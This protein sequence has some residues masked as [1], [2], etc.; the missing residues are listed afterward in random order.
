MAY[1][2]IFILGV[3]VG[4][5]LGQFFTVQ[6]ASAQT[7]D[8]YYLTITGKF[9][10]LQAQSTTTLPLTTCSGV[11]GWSNNAEYV[12]LEFGLPAIHAS[13]TYSFN[14]GFNAYTTFQ[15]VTNA[16]GS[17]DWFFYCANPTFLTWYNSSGVALSDYYIQATSSAANLGNFFIEIVEPKYA[18]TTA[19]STVKLNAYFYYDTETAT[20]TKAQ[21][22]IFDYLSNTLE[23]EYTQIVPAGFDVNFSLDVDT[24]LATGSKKMVARY[25][26]AGSELSL[27]PQ[28]E[29]FFSVIENTYF[30]ATGLES[31]TAT[32]QDLTQIDCNTFDV[33]CQFQKALTFLF[34]PPQT[35]L[36]KFGN[37]WQ[38]LKYL[39]P[40]GYVTQ[41]FEQLGSVSAGAAGAYTIPQ[42][43]FIDTIFAPFRSGLSIMLWGI[44]AFVFYRRVKNID[45]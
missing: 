44:F 11:G 35:T 30:A 15:S 4:T 26:Y 1:S 32:A 13:N 27:I 21:I 2:A 5:I 43:P 23:Y 45:I 19:T 34:I 42:I 38:E 41:I 10:G 39:K 9:S 29:S 31:P 22:Q 24:V 20:N 37:L 40:F 16:L 36:D 18:T 17:A 8:T 3:V 12:G 25:V 14:N 6:V 7:N 33:G 28:K